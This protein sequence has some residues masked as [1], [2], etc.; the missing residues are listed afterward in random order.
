NTPT[1]GIG[2]STVEKLVNQSVKAG[3][4]FWEMVASAQQTNDLSARASTALNGFHD[5]LKRYRA[6]LEQSPRDLSR[7]M[8][9]LIKEIDYESEIK[10]QYKTSEQQQ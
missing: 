8:H 2:S 6:R 10:K 3:N 9:D 4:R 7:I 5:L 1:R